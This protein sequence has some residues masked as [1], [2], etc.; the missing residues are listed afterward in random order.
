VLITGVCE[1]CALTKSDAEL[2]TRASQLI[3]DA[4]GGYQ[5]GFCNT[6]TPPSQGDH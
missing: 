4:T 6:N 1:R 3:C 2:L 5:I